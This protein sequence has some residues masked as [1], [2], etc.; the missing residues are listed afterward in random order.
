M[1][2]FFPKYC[3]S[4]VNLKGKTVV[5]TGCNT[6]I[7]KETALNFYRRGARVIMACRSISRTQA[8]IDDIRKITEAEENVGELV[9]KHLE[10]S[11]LTSV[12]KCA[13]EILD[14]ETRIDILINNAGIMLCPKTL[15]EDGY[16]LHL[17]TNHLGH[18]LLTL[19]LLPRILRSS[20]ARIINVSSLAHNWGDQL[21]HF[22]DI[23]LE[24]NYTPSGAYGRSKLANI[25]FTVE[26]AK[27]LEG[28]G[29]N[30]YAVNPG[31]VHTE[32]SRYAD[33]TIFPGATWLYN[34]FTKYLLKTP[35][36]GCQ[37]I[38]YCALDSQCA[39]ETGLYYSDCKNVEPNPAAK[40]QNIANELWGVS[41]K[42]V[43]IDLE[44][45]YFKAD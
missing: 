7:G 39:N 17:A 9:F 24:K 45:N 20:S 34:G 10:L 36:Q 33:Q 16:E 26:L 44:S 42:L 23:N 27:R 22:E 15:S 11:F 6:G 12:R 5:I 29:I 8:A 30:V 43:K 18:F 35:E 2:Y 28:T 1:E 21:M 3:N 19:L 13:C 31:V 37:T 25:L 14:S 40:D 32:L 4:F 38:L 41:C